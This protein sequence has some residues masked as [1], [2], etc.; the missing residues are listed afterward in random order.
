MT[1]TV[2]VTF[3]VLPTSEQIQAM[4]AWITPYL[5]AGNTS[6]FPLDTIGDQLFREWDTVENAEAFM[7]KVNEIYT[8]ATNVE[9]VA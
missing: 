6:V 9:I 1:T 2:A 5:T 7:A 3:S 8:T 4:E